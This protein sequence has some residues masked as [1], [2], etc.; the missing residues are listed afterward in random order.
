MLI[1]AAG[2]RPYFGMLWI[3]VRRDRPSLKACETQ[4]QGRLHCCFV[5]RSESLGVL[6]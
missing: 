2:R 4:N 5:Y 1:A 3:T 6:T